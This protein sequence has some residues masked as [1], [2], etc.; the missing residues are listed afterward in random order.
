AS[1]HAGIAEIEDRRHKDAVFEF[2]AAEDVVARFDIGQGNTLTLLLEGC[3]FIHGDRLAY[4]IGAR[5]HQLR[6]I[7]GANLSYDEALAKS[8]PHPPT[9]TKAAGRTHTH[10]VGLP[11]IFAG[12]CA[13]DENLVAY[14]D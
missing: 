13:A 11:G 3:G 10:Q 9:T 6:P 8:I 2:P 1:H 5:D 14:F 12:R 4:T 7:D